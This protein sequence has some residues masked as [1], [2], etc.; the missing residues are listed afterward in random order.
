[1]EWGEAMTGSLKWTRGGGKEENS[2]TTQM[3]VM[4]RTAAAE[5]WMRRS[6]AASVGAAATLLKVGRTQ[7]CAKLDDRMRGRVFTRNRRPVSL[8]SD[9]VSESLRMRSMSAAA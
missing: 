4:A 3:L 2:T 9:C 5:G 7:H 1:M 6:G 8:D